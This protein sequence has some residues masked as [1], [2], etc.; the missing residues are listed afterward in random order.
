MKTKLYF[1][2]SIILMSYS[3][4]ANQCVS[5]KES[6][7]HLIDQM[8]MAISNPKSPAFYISKSENANH[9]PEGQIVSTGFCT[10]EAC[11]TKSSAVE[12][13][14]K[15]AEESGMKSQ[16][17]GTLFK[18]ECLVASSKFKAN[19]D[20]I[21]C[22]SNERTQKSF[23]FCINTEFLNYQNE[24]ISN[25]KACADASNIKTL[26]AAHLFK[27]YTLES[28]FKPY[29]SYS[30][31][32]GIGQLTSVFVK[33]LHEKHR[34][35][36][37]LKK[38]AALK[39]PQ[40]KGAQMIAESDLKSPPSHA[41]KCAFVTVGSGLERN[42]L[43]SI[44]GL[45][46]SWEKDIEPKLRSYLKKYKSH[47]RIEEV[48]NLALL[49][50]YGPGRADARAAIVRLSDYPPDEFIAAMKKPLPSK[51]GNLTKY[52]TRIEAKQKEL[53]QDFL[54]EPLK[55]EYAKNGA[56]SCVN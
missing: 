3:A 41:D 45:A 15:F 26:D 28:A 6:S 25:F 55:S 21:K 14:K 56:Q 52:I 50:S 12:D 43:Y 31:G 39:S 16:K 9:I 30:G 22:P 29:Y 35:R 27:M 11:R 53:A 40:C 36:K 8:K 32:V 48:K 7:T 19:T 13:L 51:R 24:V 33:D 37:N 10:E 38:I 23:N 54:Q 47:P 4:L 49:N 44:L 18:T 5:G 17:N 1:S 34:G 2:V 46:T 20:E 42:I